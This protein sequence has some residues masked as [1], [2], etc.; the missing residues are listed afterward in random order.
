MT[1]TLELTDEALANLNTL[2]EIQHKSL[3]AVAADVLEKHLKI[4]R[5]EEFQRIANYVMDK[6]AELYRRLA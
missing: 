6:S 1:L 3:E 5:D 2:A 4:E